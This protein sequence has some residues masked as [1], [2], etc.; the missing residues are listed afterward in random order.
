MMKYLAISKKFIISILAVMFAICLSVG[1]STIKVN[2][3]NELESVELATTMRERPQIRLVAPTG[4]RFIVDLN[5]SDLDKFNDDFQ[6]VVMITQKVLLDKA[7]VSVSDFDKDTDVKKGQVSFVKSELP[8]AND[9][10][11]TLMATILNVSDNNISKTYVAKAYITDGEK[12]GYVE[13][14]CQASIYEVA[15]YWKNHEAFV[16][17]EE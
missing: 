4:M 11:I 14:A 12:I 3:A 10:V 6:V 17:E 2:A 15:K 1:F 8:K 5:E 13:Q 9:G 16:D 7:G